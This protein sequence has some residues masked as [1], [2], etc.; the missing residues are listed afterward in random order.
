[1]KKQSIIVM[2][3][4]YESEYSVIELQGIHFMKKKNFFFFKF[5]FVYYRMNK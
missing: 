1:M 5:C 2:S 3:N 4:K